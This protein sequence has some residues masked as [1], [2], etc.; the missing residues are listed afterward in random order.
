[1]SNY[2]CKEWGVCSWRWLAVLVLMIAPAICLG[3]QQ[4]YV[5]EN[6]VIDADEKVKTQASLMLRELSIRVGDTLSVH[7]LDSLKKLN[8]DR[9]FNLQLFNATQI[10]FDTTHGRLNAVIKVQERFPIW[11]DVS[12]TLGDRNFNVWAREYQFALNRVN[13]GIKLIHKNIGGRRIQLYAMGQLGYTPKLG[14]GLLLPFIDKAQRHGLGANIYTMHNREVAYDITTTNKLLFYKDYDKV[15]YRETQFELFY[16][17]RPAYAWQN[18]LALRLARHAIAD[19]V[20]G[21]NPN[22]LVN[23]TTKMQLLQLAYRAEYNGLDNWNYPLRGKRLI[24]TLQYTEALNTLY[25]QLVFHL[26]LDYYKEF[27]PRWY[28]SLDMKA[29]WALQGQNSYWYDKNLGYGNDYIRGYEY[30]V[31]HGRSM[32][33]GRLD[34]KHELLRHSFSLPFKYFQ[35]IPLRLYPKVFMDI[36]IAQDNQQETLLGERLLYSFGIGLDILTLYDIKLRIEFAYNHL[37]ER[38]I[39]FHRQGN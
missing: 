19:T 28:L 38:D 1:M 10:D 3:Q 16:L 25:R 30:Y 5:I 13:A 6:I 31:M 21:L 20:Q 17:Y 8:E 7:H 36:G 2:C 34:I 18:R 14:A 22:F 24:G 9:L 15:L 26:Q 29:R 4:G 37:K 23:G 33:F 35:T 11:P 32:V 27:F 39:Y 12:F